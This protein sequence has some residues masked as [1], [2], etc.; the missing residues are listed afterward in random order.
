MVLTSPRRSAGTGI[1]SFLPSR[2]RQQGQ[3]GEPCC[4]PGNIHFGTMPSA[5][6]GLILRISS[7]ELL[8]REASEFL[9][10]RTGRRVTV[11]FLSSQVS[12]SVVASRPAGYQIRL[13]EPLDPD[14]V[15]VLLDEYGVESSPR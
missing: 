13:T 12:G 11:S 9:L 7:T 8:F 5:S 6:D 3:P 4:I 10:D 14:M 1:T 15:A 2:S